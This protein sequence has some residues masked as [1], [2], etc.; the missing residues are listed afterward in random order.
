MKL[1]SELPNGDTDPAREYRGRGSS[2]YESPTYS[3]RTGFRV[4]PAQ[5]RSRAEEFHAKTATR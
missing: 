5:E 1:R 4:L 3:L 2:F